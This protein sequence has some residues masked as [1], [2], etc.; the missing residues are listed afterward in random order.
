MGNPRAKTTVALS[1]DGDV[2]VFVKGDQLPDWA[3]AEITN[4]EVVDQ[5]EEAKAD[6]DA[7]DGAGTDD[8]GDGSADGAG[9]GDAAAADD[10]PPADEAPK[11]KTRARRKPA[12]K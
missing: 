12:T 10:A 11:P 7:G 1:H 8:A 5:P 6:A 9:D 3:L 2:H 4:P